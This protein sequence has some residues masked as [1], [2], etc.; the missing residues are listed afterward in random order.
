MYLS[1]R[2]PMARVYCSSGSRAAEQN[3]HAYTLTRHSRMWPQHRQQGTSFGTAFI[4]IQRAR[5][6]IAVVLSICYA[7][8]FYSVAL[9]AAEFGHNPGCTDVAQERFYCG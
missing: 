3:C 2:A 5:G 1:Q 9:P 4:C 8:L 6:D 7:Y